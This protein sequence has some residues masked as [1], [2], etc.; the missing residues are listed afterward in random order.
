MKLITDSHDLINYL[1]K[2]VTNVELATDKF[3][4]CMI[5]ISDQNDKTIESDV[6]SA[7]INV[8]VG[9]GMSG[10]EFH[11]MPMGCFSENLYLIV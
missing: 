7:F 6:K 2:Y 9:R 10:Q 3:E 8:L 11:H 1:S 5:K 4:K